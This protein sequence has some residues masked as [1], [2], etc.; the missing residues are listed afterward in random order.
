MQATL[1]PTPARQRQRHLPRTLID[2][3]ALFTFMRALGADTP[4]KICRELGVLESVVS[5]LVS[6]GGRTSLDFV[7]LLW[8]KYPLQPWDK[9]LIIPGR[10]KRESKP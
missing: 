1:E 5:R 10:T 8:S 4:A 6:T 2:V 9:F 7:A 3:D